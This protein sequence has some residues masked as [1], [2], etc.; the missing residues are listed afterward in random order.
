MDIQLTNGS[1]ARSSIEVEF[2]EKTFLISI[3]FSLELCFL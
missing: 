1:S 3:P 2:L